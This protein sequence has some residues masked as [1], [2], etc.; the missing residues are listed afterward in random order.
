MKQKFS[1]TALQYFKYLTDDKIDELFETFRGKEHNQTF[2]HSV[3]KHIVSNTSRQQ[4]RMA[5]K[6]E[7]LPA[8][9]Q[10]TIA[11]V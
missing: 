8:L 10:P 3:C 9:T 6:T 11:T 4:L 1:I 5:R 7:Y 2:E